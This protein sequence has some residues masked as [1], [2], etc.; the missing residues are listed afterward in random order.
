MPAPL[1][2]ADRQFLGELAAGFATRDRTL[3]D[4]L[5]AI[6]GKWGFLPRAALEE[7]GFEARLARE[8][9]HSAA[10]FYTGFRYEPPPEVEIRVCDTLTCHLA[11][12]ERVLV[13]ARG[14]ADAYGAG[15]WEAGPAPCLGLCEQ[16][17]AMLVNG[18]ACSARAG[19]E[20][21][22]A[23][24]RMGAA[25]PSLPRLAAYRAEGGYALLDRAAREPA[26]ATQ[27]LKASGLRGMGGAGF[28]A[29]SKWEFVQRAKGAPKYVVLNADEGEPGT[30]KDR[31]LL[32]TRPHAVL[33]GMLLAMAGV[34]AERGVIYLR[35]EYGA[36][37]AALRSAMAEIQE[38]GLVG[39]PWPNGVTP[40]LQLVVGAGSY[41]CGEETAM[42]ESIEGKRGEPRLKPP[43][44]AQVGL[45]GKPTLI[46]NVETLAW[47]P[48]ILAQGSA[49]WRAQGREGSPGRK[50]LSVSGHVNEPGVVDVP[51]GVTFRELF[52]E[53]AGG[54]PRGAPPKAF[55]P[56]GLASGLLPWSKADVRVDFDAL[57]KEG[58]MLGSGGVVAIPP[59]TCLVELAENGLAFFAHESCGKCTPCRAGTEKLLHT[60]RALRAGR[61]SREQVA[62]MGELSDAMAAAS[63]CGLGQT[64]MNP[65]LHGLRFFRE[66]FEA[67]LEGRCP[68]GVCR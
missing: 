35:E 65:F 47:V 9:V 4:C 29:G 26:W 38:A 58:S 30:F 66:E 56:G 37:G 42:L 36:A 46:H 61:A 57:A 12:A 22:I 45:W 43:Y 40:A 11:G 10:T 28:P 19:V 31:W 15:R 44:P 51:L 34:G 32:E 5:H 55:V 27:E 50:L 13:Q 60:C 21:A 3:L 53:H 1:A 16:A 63:I 20:P 33:D 41:V 39:K 24:A 2:D 23:A 17:P 48:R 68:E 67:H 64:A 62:L 54:F 49:W 52:E 7:F 6:Q 14:L 59:G 18:A 8:Q 25:R